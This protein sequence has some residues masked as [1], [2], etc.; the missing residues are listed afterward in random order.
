MEIKV[1]ERAELTLVFDNQRPV[2]VTDLGRSLQALGREYEEFVV[3]RFEPPP[4]NS[5]LYVAHVE[6]G[7]IILTLQALLDQAS[8]M[9][10]HIEVF[11]GFIANLQEII[12]FLLTQQGKAKAPAAIS[13]SSVERISTIV[14]P[15]AKD[16]GSNLTITLNVSGNT[17]PVLV[18]P[19][20]INSERANALQNSA[21]RYLGPNSQLMETSR[22]SCCTSIK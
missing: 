1:L 7:S 18:Q 9:V 11:A 4:V 6:S 15:V 5:R 16:G 21:R 14:E 8:F 2:D 17:A 22:A 13:H 10:K 20:I 3:G 19:I 12:D